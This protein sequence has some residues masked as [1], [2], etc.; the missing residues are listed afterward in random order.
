MEHTV[1]V[2]YTTDKEKNAII[3]GCTK[4]INTAET[5]AEKCQINSNS[6]YGH[7]YAELDCPIPPY[8]ARPS[9]IVCRVDI[10][11]GDEN[12]EEYKLEVIVDPRLNDIIDET[13]IVYNLYKNYNE[14]YFRFRL[15]INETDSYDEIMKEANKL[16]H[17]KYETML[18]NNDKFIQNIDTFFKEREDHLNKLKEQ[19][20]DISKWIKL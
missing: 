1:Y 9:S 7:F 17:D 14:F 12:R 8:Y 16:A 10:T 5:F 13:D 15:D 6:R 3:L 19:T 11:I 2:V 4:N 20:K 18:K